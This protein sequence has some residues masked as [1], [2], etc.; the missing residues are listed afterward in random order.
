MNK[1]SAA[2]PSALE[3]GKW[4]K[5]TRTSL[6]LSLSELADRLKLPEQ[7][8]EALEGENFDALPGATYTRAYLKSIAEEL[9]MDKEEMLRR[10]YF[11]TRQNP[12]R[13][14]V[15]TLS[16]DTSGSSLE[17]KRKPA[18]GKMIIATLVLLVLVMIGKFAL[19]NT[20]DQPLSTATSSV[21]EYS[22][23]TYSSL[24]DSL[25]NDSLTQE[26]DPAK[27]SLMLDSIDQIVETDS[28]LKELVE[29][30]VIPDSVE[31]K[32]KPKVVDQGTKISIKVEK[33]S[34]WFLIKSKSAPDDARWLREWQKPITIYR[35]DTVYIEFGTIRLVEVKIND[36]LITPRRNLFSVFNGQML[37]E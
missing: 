36:R 14:R 24:S 10:Y 6:G 35:K 9:S 34:T 23:V 29:P 26:I 18:Y 31:I 17:E 11:L 7:A 4:I 33:D 5:D 12:D 25:N 16:F 21:D 19:G 1:E 37:K 13:D 2:S 8:L 28:S 32:E 27:D 15:P 30:Q 3:L 20:E 22:P